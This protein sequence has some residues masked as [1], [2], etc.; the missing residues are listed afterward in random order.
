[1]EVPLVLN[2]SYNSAFELFQQSDFPKFRLFQSYYVRAD[3][4]YEW[5]TAHGLGSYCP[6]QWVDAFGQKP[7]HKK[8]LD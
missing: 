4:L 1:M 6:Q 7:N 3:R 2:I 5:L 8:G